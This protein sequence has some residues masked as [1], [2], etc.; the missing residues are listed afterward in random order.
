M[1]MSTVPAALLAFRTEGFSAV[2]WVIVIVAVIHAIEAYGINPLIYGKHLKM[3]PIMIILILLIGEH[4]F[5][6]WGLL[7]GVPV[8][9]FV[10]KYVIEGAEWEEKAGE[11][12]E[13][14]IEN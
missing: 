7:L 6:L 5:G 8:S 4:V 12:E 2:L 1:I 11:E 3:H 9:A 13:L 10:I 14:R